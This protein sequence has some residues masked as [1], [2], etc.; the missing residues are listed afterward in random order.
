ME[1]CFKG[2]WTRGRTYTHQVTTLTQPIEIPTTEG[3]GA[4]VGVDSSEEGFGGFTSATQ[5]ERTKVVT[6]SSS[7]R[8]ARRRVDR[9]RAKKEGRTREE[10]GTWDEETHFNPVAS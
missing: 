6:F 10:E 9:D 7:K 1:R 2:E 8:A 4:E 3:E 5:T